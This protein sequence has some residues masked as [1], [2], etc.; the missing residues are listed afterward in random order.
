[1]KE[2]KILDIYPE[3]VERLL[4]GMLKY[5]VSDRLTSDKALEMLLNY[6]KAQLKLI[7][8]DDFDVLKS[9]GEKYRVY[10]PC[11]KEIFFEGLD[12]ICLY[13]EDKQ[14]KSHLIK[15]KLFF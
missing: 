8:H 3:I 15:F 4:E 12:T 14:R 11:E 1:M 2:N 6:K 10:D 9:K 5:E 7:Y 13:T